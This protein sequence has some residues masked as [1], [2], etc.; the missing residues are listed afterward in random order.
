[1]EEAAVGMRTNT[2]GQVEVTRVDCKPGM[3]RKFFV[4]VLVRKPLMSFL[5]ALDGVVV[6]ASSSGFLLDF[7]AA[8]KK[9]V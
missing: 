2:I 8:G 1:M 9:V 7:L 4:P 6:G 3:G 5:G